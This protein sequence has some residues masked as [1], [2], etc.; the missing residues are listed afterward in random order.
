MKNYK[1]FGFIQTFLLLL[2]SF[3]LLLPNFLPIRFTPLPATKANWDQFEP[4]LAARL[5]SVDALLRYSDSLAKSRGTGQDTL[6]Y[7]NTLAEV[8]RKRF[9]HGYSHYALN[10]NWIA[11]LAGRIVWSDLSAIVLPDDIMN[12]SM[13]ACSQ[14]SIV[15]MECFKRKGIDYRKIGFDHHFTLEGKIQ[16]EWYFFDTNMEP[17][18]SSVPRTSFASLRENNKLYAVYRAQL[19]SAHLNYTLA[20][21]YYGKVN[22]PAA[23]RAA[24]FHS[25][26]RLLSRTLW[27][28]P[29]LVVFIRRTKRNRQLVRYMRHEKP[30]AFVE[31]AV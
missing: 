23:P 27:L 11:A 18:F 16:G 12:Y 5:H 2:L 14:Q 21:Q 15:M 26:T 9:Y 24:L 28:F 6:K 1:T 19:D 10:E 25:L 13:A 20:N 8:V 22:K 4:A 7:A 17:D 3:V 29:L 31:T 30:T